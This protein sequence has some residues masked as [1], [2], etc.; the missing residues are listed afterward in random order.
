MFSFVGQI[1][2]IALRSR[3]CTKFRFPPI[4][5]KALVGQE[6]E[7]EDLK[8]M[9]E[10]CFDLLKTVETIAGECG[11]DEGK[12]K[13]SIGEL[14]FVT[15]LT[16][17]DEKELVA[18]G[19]SLCVGL[20]NYKLFVERML[21]VRL[22]EGVVALRAICGGF[23][24]V[25]PETVLPLFNWEEMELLVCGKAGV[26]I[27]LLQQNTEYD[28]DVC[29]SDEHIISFWRVLRGMDDDDRSQLLK[30]VWAR[31]RL[32]NTQEEFHQRFKIQACNYAEPDKYLPKAHTCF[33]SLNLPRYSCD[34]IMRER[35]LYAIWNCVEM[36]ADF[37]LADSENASWF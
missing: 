30:F 12:F 21:S 16:N 1:I 5:W 15:K 33:F 24:S 32:P 17:G 10:A 14:F 8:H 9:D 27:D 25:I 29:A 4:V 28:D 31:E 20:D 23:C 34:E 6:F 13:D 3:I 7:R 35:L 11:G 18:G 22:N 36:D 2:G 19:R 26:D 37:K